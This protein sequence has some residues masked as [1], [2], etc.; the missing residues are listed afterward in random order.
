MLPFWLMAILTAQ[1]TP[2][3]TGNLA[4]S[5]DCMASSRNVTTTGMT[6][7]KWDIY[8]SPSA[9]AHLRA[10]FTID[11]PGP[12]DEYKIVGMPFIEDGEWY[13]CGSTAPKTLHSCRYQWQFNN[14]SVGFVMGW[15]CSGK[16]AKKP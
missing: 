7:M 4:T 14:A 10:T 5:A 13:D 11:N 12:G 6:M 8:H 15:L 1:A 9:K 3:S 16:D 2:L